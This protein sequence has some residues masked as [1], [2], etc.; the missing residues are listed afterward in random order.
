MQL[1]IVYQGVISQRAQVSFE[2]YMWRCG[3]ATIKIDLEK[4]LQK[5]FRW[6]LFF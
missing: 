6:A 3:V 4:I 5:Q 2:Q 1:K